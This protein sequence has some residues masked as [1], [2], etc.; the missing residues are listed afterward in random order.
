MSN[1]IKNR[2]LRLLALVMAGA[3]LLTA[4]FASAGSRVSLGGGRADDTEYETYTNETACFSLEY[5][6]GGQVETPYD[7]GVFITVAD[8]FRLG[9]EYAFSL[10]DEVFLYSAADMAALLAADEDRLTEWTGA[11]E[12][13]VVET[14]KMNTSMGECFRFDYVSEVEGVPWSGCL[15]IFNG[16][17]DFG[18]YCLQ[19]LIRDDDDSGACWDQFD[20]VIDS[21]RITDAYQVEGITVY[22]V[23]DWD[24]E[25]M[26]QDENLSDAEYTDDPVG[27][28]LRLQPADTTLSQGSILMDKLTCGPEEDIEDIMDDSLAFI[29]ENKENAQTLVE[30]HTGE[31][32]G[33]YPAGSYM[34]SYTEKGADVYVTHAYVGTDDGWWCLA[35]TSDEDHL[36]AVLTTMSDLLVSL[37]FG[38]EGNV[39]VNDSV[40]AILDRIEGQEDFFAGGYPRPVASVTDVNGDGRMEFLAIYEIHAG[41]SNAIMYDVWSIREGGAQLLDQ[42]TLYVEAGA[43]MG[44]LFLY[45]KDGVDY[46]CKWTGIYDDEDSYTSRSEY[47]PLS[48]DESQLLFDEAVTLEIFSPSDGDS[49]YYVN[50]KEVTEDAYD[51]AKGSFQLLV[52]LNW[53]G[54]AFAAPGDETT[55]YDSMMS[56]DEL[57]EYDFGS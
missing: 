8:G 43:S 31:Y 45:E 16:Q 47:I 23:P 30:P 20:H 54:G 24:L 21:F 38:G 41:S 34:A 15:V 44:T 26:V 29:L 49:E 53:F 52:V 4:G 3:M 56:F 33:R 39:K 12:L 46:L 7:N 1:R 35:G 50:G 13:D 36:D 51:Q 22:E 5:P 57:R 28:S 14:G 27:Q 40:A 10:N 9:A 48:E 17:G 25:F 19:A 2:L 6:A 37:R 55:P 32:I 42:G 11:E 18:C